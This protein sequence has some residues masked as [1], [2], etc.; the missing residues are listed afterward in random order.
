MIHG[1]RVIAS[2]HV[3][4]GS[5]YMLLTIKISDVTI[6]RAIATPKN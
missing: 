1:M 5:L 4:A 3:F 2:K 6:P